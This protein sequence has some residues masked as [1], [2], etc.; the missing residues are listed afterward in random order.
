MSRAEQQHLC[1]HP[2]SEGQ[3][4]SP[5]A[6]LSVSVG[7]PA[8][9]ERRYPGTGIPGR[10][11]RLSASTASSNSISGRRPARKAW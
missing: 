8:G 2:A 11:V 6:N 10:L 7:D 5:D 3:H 4:R 9:P 1:E